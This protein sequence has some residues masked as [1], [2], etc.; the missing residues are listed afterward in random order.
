MAYCFGKSQKLWGTCLEWLIERGKTCFR[1]EIPERVRPFH[2][3]D[4]TIQIL[5]CLQNRGFL[6]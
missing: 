2:F 3:T 1:L 6:C 5:L 4:R